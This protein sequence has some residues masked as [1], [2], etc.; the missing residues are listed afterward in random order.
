[1]YPQIA[2]RPCDE[3]KQFLYDDRGNLMTRGGPGGTP[4]A[5]PKGSKPPCATCPKI[6]PGTERPGPEQAVELSADLRQAFQFYRECKAVGSFPNDPIV[7]WLSAQFAAA[8]SHC[9]KV[10][11]HRSQLTVLA[12][13]RDS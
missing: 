7:R 13:V 11:A 2:A 4:V 6:P 9:D 5:R 1:M 3:C 8:E 12:A 10:S